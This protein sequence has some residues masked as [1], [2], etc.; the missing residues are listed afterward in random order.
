M[1]RQTSDWR[2]DLWGKPS[3]ADRPPRGNPSEAEQ[4]GVPEREPGTSWEYN[5]VCVN[6]LAYAAL[7]AWR[8]PLPK[9]LDRLVMTPI[10]ASGTWRWHGYSTSWG[11]L[12]GQYVQS[13]SGGGHH[14]GGMFVSTRDQARFGLLCLRDGRWGERQIIP[15]AWIDYARQP[16]DVRPDYGIMNWFLNAEGVDSDGKAQRTWPA[17]PAGA[18][19]FRGAGSNLVYFDSEV[20]LLIVLRWFDN[21]KLN[22]LLERVYAA[23]VALP[24]GGR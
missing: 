10:G 18:V 4:R 7:E 13:V 21:T 22:A 8:E 16:T 9:V 11:P 15:K 17:A 5:D 2:G 1:L 23:R 3:W 14:G 6:L 19:C 24:T 12:D 20:D